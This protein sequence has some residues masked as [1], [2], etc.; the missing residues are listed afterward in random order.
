MILHIF[1]TFQPSCPDL[2]QHAPRGG[3]VTFI[4]LTPSRV[5]WYV[6][7]RGD[8]SYKAESADSSLR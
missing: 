1:T 7:D 6:R 2:S 8:L 3:R 5:R 4:V